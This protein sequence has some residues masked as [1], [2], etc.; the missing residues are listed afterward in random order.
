MNCIIGV[1]PGVSGA[2][3]FYYPDDAPARIAVYDVPIAGGEI[4]S[5]GLADLITSHGATVAWIERVGAMPGNGGSSM[6]NFGRAYGDVR[7]VIG[8]LKIP[9]HFVTPQVWKKHFNLDKDKDKSR[10]L[11]IRMFPNV[12]EHFKRKKDDGRAEAALVALYGHHQQN[13]QALAA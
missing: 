6:F 7:G 10:M 12:A 9:T 4:N 8:A 5:P 2:L 11:A 1:D 13:R 3:A